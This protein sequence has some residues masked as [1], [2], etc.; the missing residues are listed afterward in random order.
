[1]LYDLFCRLEKGN[2][3]EVLNIVG[4]SLEATKNGVGVTFQITHWFWTGVKKAE[5]L[6]RFHTKQNRGTD[7]TIG[8]IECF[9]LTSQ[10]LLACYSCVKKKL[11]LGRKQIKMYMLHMLQRYNI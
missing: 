9:L 6:E 8:K 7:G 5:L 4:W 1:M 11:L 10:L 2:I 3:E